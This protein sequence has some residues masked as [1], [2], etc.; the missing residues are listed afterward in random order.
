MKHLRGIL[1]LEDGRCFIGVSFGYEGDSTGEVVFNTSMTGYQEVITDMS[2]AGQIVAMTAPLIGNTGFNDDDYESQS[3]RIC[4]FLVREFS[5]QY[6]N[7]RAKEGLGEFFNRHKIAAL[8][9]IDTR[10]L[11]MHLR[12]HGLLRAVIAAGD[13]DSAELVRKAKNSPR[14]E[15]LDLVGQLTTQKP[16]EWTESCNWISELYSQTKNSFTNKNRLNRILVYDFGVKQNIMRSLLSV[17]RLGNNNCNDNTVTANNEN[18]SSKVI[19]VPASMSAEEALE[20]KPDGI[21]LSNGPGDPARLNSIVNEIK[22]LIGKV[23]IFGICLGQQLLA[24]AFGATTFKMKFGHRGANQPV[25]NKQTGKVEITSQNH[26]FCVD[27]DSLP[28]CVEV[29]HVNLND[30]TV[31]GLR[32]LEYP[33]FSVQY[34]PEAAAGP[35]DATYLFEQFIFGSCR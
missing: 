18:Y 28:K 26:S 8:S 15:E 17:M 3:P 24:R 20:L 14:L 35:H 16:F 34:H 11:T 9:E 10:T 31:E 2:Y 27:P 1:A 19:V 12:S 30:G 25:L 32:H 7:W 29:S 21:V 5:E 13:W 6:S 22:K 4:G 23:P 33:I